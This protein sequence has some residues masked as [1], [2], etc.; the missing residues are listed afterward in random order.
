M[1][2]LMTTPRPTSTLP[3]TQMAAVPSLD[4]TALPFLMAE[5]RTSNTLL[6]TTTVMSLM[7]PTREC[8]TT[9][10][11]SPTTLPLPLTTPLHPTMPKC[12]FFQYLI[13]IDLIKQ[14]L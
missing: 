2:S 13:F 9:P 4:L 10:R 1:E 8:L 5:P 6:T 11:L 7:S 3:R 14:K 12:L